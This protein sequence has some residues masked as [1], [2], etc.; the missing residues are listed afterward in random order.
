M[1]PQGPLQSRRPRRNDAGIGP[2]INGLGDYTGGGRFVLDRSKETFWTSNGSS[3]GI[4]ASDAVQQDRA[5]GRERLVVLPHFQGHGIRPGCQ[6]R[7]WRSLTKSAHSSTS[8]TRS[9]LG[10][11]DV[12]AFHLF[13]TD[14]IK[15]LPWRPSCPWCWPWW[16]T[17]LREIDKGAQEYVIFDRDQAYPWPWPW[18]WPSAWDS[19]TQEQDDLQDLPGR[20]ARRARDWTRQAN[21]GLSP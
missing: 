9:S 10:S 13:W 19:M 1:L 8:S 21:M 12:Q 4:A 17:D 2:F 6:R 16:T 5:M 20:R 14:K 3:S 18:D 11:T 15:E 7:W